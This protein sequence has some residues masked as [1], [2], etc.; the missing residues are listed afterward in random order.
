MSDAILSKLV[1]SAIAANLAPTLSV[2]GAVP[3]TGNIDVGDTIGW[4]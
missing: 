1:A 2:E 4:T 3:Q